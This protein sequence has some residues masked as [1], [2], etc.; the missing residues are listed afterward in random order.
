MFREQL[1]VSDNP[2]D[3]ANTISNRF[4][5]NDVYCYN[6]LPE[7]GVFEKSVADI[8][9][10]EWGIWSRRMLNLRRWDLI[11]PENCI[12]DWILNNWA[13]KKP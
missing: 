7:P 4:H 11:T 10:D 3:P 9:D 1:T 2:S 12:E 6:E 8:L 13:W 5:L